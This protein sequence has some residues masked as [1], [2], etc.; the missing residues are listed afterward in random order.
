[1]PAAASEHAC[2]GPSPICISVALTCRADSIASFRDP[3]PEKKKMEAA[4]PLYARDLMILAGDIA[5]L[6]TART[7]G[8][9]RDASAGKAVTLV[10][11]EGDNLLGVAARASG[12]VRGADLRL[13]ELVDVLAPIA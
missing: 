1:M 4:M 12:R 9:A 2:D 5:S 7:L 8:E 10:L 13:G 6:G 3:C 11:D